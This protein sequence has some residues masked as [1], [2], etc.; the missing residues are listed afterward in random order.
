MTCPNL[1]NPIVREEFKELKDVLGE[2]MA[3]L[4]WDRNNGYH[5]DKTRD[6]KPSKLFSDLVG[7]SNRN[8]AIEIKA[9]TLSNAFKQWFGDS[10]VIDENGEPLVVY[11]SSNNKFEMFKKGFK[12]FKD[13]DVFFFTPEKLISESYGENVYPVFLNIRNPY[14]QSSEENWITDQL[15]K[16]H[17]QEMRQLN[18]DGLIG[19]GGIA[20]IDYVAFEPNQI[21]SIFNSGVFNRYSDNIYDN[22]ILMK[23]ENR[24]QTRINGSM[25]SE[26][27]ENFENYF[28]NYNFFNDDQRK[29]VA[30]LV[31]E[32]KIQLNCAI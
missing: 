24:Q 20:S 3:Y 11:H 18:H 27:L 6:G 8:K 4:I 25:Y 29:I 23:K 19:E 12:N 14:E 5:L 17:F 13:L 9:K 10:K 28:P 32:G 1:S 22:D 26:I 21:K 7:L 16:N 31:E 2:D 15:E 30:S